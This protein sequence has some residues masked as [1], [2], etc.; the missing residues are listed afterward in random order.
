MS[1]CG[2]ACVGGRAITKIPET[3]GDGS[4]RGIG[5]VN[6]QR[7][8]AACWT[9]GKSGDRNNGSGARNSIGRVAGIIRGEDHSVA[10]GPRAAGGKTDH[11][12]SGTK[13]RQCEVCPGRNRKCTGGYGSE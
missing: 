7:F 5:E 2:D 1:K 4:S 6:G 9:T 13:S 12:I 8:E 10:K 3:V 11:Q